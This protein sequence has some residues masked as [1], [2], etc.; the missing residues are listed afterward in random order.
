MNNRR[1]RVDVEEER[2]NFQGDEALICPK[3]RTTAVATTTDRK[4][5]DGADGSVIHAAALA[6]LFAIE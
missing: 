5:P 4:T 6:Y 2:W 1:G 3:G